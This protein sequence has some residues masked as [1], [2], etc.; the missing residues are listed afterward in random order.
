MALFDLAD[1]VTE[2]KGFPLPVKIG[3]G[4][5]GGATVLFAVHA[6]MAARA[7]SASSTGLQ[8]IS[9]VTSQPADTPGVWSGGGT[10]PTAGNPPPAVAPPVKSGGGGIHPPVKPPVHV[11][12]VP[13]QRPS[14]YIVMPGDSLSRIAMKNHLSL[15][16]IEAMN[17]QYRANFN[18]IQPGQKVKLAA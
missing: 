12:P 17:P 16:Q 9:S 18:L 15:A 14:S 5:A 1:I 7:N 10:V 4:V 11:K 3:I 2:W 6:L 8:P 13:V